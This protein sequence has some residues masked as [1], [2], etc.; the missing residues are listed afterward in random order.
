MVKFSIELRF[1]ERR[2]VAG[3][4]ALDFEFETR[5]VVGVETEPEIS[6]LF[7]KDCIQS[8]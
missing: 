2:P 6:W 5:E 4:R 8:Q 7:N 1:N 3:P